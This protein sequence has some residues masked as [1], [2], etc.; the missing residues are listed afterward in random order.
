[1]ARLL[2]RVLQVRAAVGY[3]GARRPEGSDLRRHQTGRF[4]EQFPAIQCCGLTGH[5]EVSLKHK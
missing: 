2:D 1:M 3:K 5:A 4:A